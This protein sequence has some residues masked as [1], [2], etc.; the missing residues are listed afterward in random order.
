VAIGDGIFLTGAVITPLGEGEPRTLDAEQAGALAQTIIAQAFWGPAGIKQDPPPDLPVYRIELSGD[1]AGVVGV[2]TVHYTD[3]G[4]TPY[5]A[6]PGLVITPEPIDPPPD[7]ENWFTVPRL[8]MD[9]F[10]GRGELADTSGRLSS[11]ATTTPLAAEDASD[12]G[13]DSSVLPIALAAGVAVLAVGG[14]WA[15]QRRRGGGPSGAGDDG[16]TESGEP[17][18]EVPATVAS[19]D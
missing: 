17:A 7:P 1:F 12:G 15:L 10:N 5:V 3:D 6:F 16:P 11:P 9:A 19:D 13:S 2:L 18:E 4:T 14:L 8:A